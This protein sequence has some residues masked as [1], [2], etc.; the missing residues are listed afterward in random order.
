[1]NGLART[2]TVDP[3]TTVTH[4]V[5]EPLAPIPVPHPP[6]DDPYGRAPGSRR[7]SGAPQGAIEEVEG[8]TYAYRYEPREES[9]GIPSFPPGVRAVRGW[10]RRRSDAQ[11]LAAAAAIEVLAVATYE[12]ALAAPG[13]AE[14]GE[15]LSDFLRA[16][17]HEHQEHLAMITG[18][19]NDVR[20]T[21]PRGIDLAPLA[22]LDLARPKLGTPTAIV[23]LALS[24]EWRAA[25]SYGAD[26]A[27]LA[28]P[29]ARKVVA[30]IL[31]AES[32]HVAVLAA[33][34]SILAA[35]SGDH[36]HM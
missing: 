8:M 18:A 31:G 36:S 7:G 12:A 32:R 28:D 9:P 17:L 5:E 16:T 6:G 3:P 35:T 1:M 27:N 21:P 26:V 19:L 2:E 34:Q 23:N 29:A 25:E 10:R 33:T 4:P 30:T 20:G 13:V 11:I 22:S 15:D 24:T 14:A